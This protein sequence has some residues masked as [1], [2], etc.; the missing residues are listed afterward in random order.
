MEASQNILNDFANEQNEL[1]TKP[2]S[3]GLAANPQGSVA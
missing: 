2:T 3:Y 1:N